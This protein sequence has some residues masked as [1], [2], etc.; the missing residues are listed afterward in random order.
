VEETLRR[1]APID[2]DEIDRAAAPAA[3]WF[4]M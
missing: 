1:L 3:R 4:S 2:L